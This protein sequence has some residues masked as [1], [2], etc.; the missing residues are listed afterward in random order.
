MYGAGVLPNG[1]T[2]F[3][4]NWPGTLEVETGDKSTGCCSH[5]PISFFSRKES[6][7]QRKKAVSLRYQP[8][9]GGIVTIITILHCKCVVAIGIKCTAKMAKFEYIMRTL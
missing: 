3:H 8:L 5:R 1:K 7:L 2:M 6:R 9:M 4:E